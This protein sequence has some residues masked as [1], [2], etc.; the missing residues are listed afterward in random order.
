MLNE[1]IRMFACV[2]MVGYQHFVMGENVRLDYGGCGY[3]CFGL[4]CVCVCV[5]CV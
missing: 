5:M 1:A 4:Y 2:V 3:I